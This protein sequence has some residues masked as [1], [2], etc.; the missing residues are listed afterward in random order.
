MLG[1]AGDRLSGTAGPVGPSP[2]D[3]QAG[4]VL[5]QRERLAVCLGHHQIPERALDQTIVAFTADTI[6]PVTRSGWAVHVQGRAALAGPGFGT[7]CC[8]PATAQ[9]VE[10][11]PAILTGYYVH[12][13]PFIDSLLQGAARFAG[14]AD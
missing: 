4:P 11:M 1:T 8:Y 9:V 2:A 10:I 6:D 12:M 3:D 13:C 5:P 14:S 7:D